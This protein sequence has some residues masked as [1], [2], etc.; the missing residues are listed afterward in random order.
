MAH[1][2]GGITYSVPKDKIIGHFLLPGI[3]CPH[4][5]LTITL[6]HE[7]KAYCII[8]G[9]M[10][11]LPFGRCPRKLKVRRVHYR[12]R[13]LVREA[14]QRLSAAVHPHTVRTFVSHSPCD[15]FRSY[16][17][18]PE[19]MRRMIEQSPEGGWEEGVGASIRWQDG[20]TV[21]RNRLRTF[22][23]PRASLESRQTQVTS[24]GS[25]RGRSVQERPP[26]YG[27]VTPLVRIHYLFDPCS[28]H[29]V[30]PSSI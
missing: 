26:P 6:R 19:M 14:S 5:P 30:R 2:I 1:C 28:N 11:S 18:K 29:G 16:S 17:S 21:G 15:I 27:S 9:R 8:N 25:V 12:C 20:G 24:P 13:S 7:H 23:W 22:L 4:Q 3:L 10:T